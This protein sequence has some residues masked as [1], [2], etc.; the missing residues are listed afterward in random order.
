MF[1]GMG[2]GV[3][4]FSIVF[5]FFIGWFLAYKM[6]LDQIGIKEQMLKMLFYSILISG[7]TF[8]EM[9]MIWGWTVKYLF[10]ENFNI[11]NFGHP[12]ILYDP[13]ISFIGWLVLMIIISPLLQLL[14]AIFGFYIT[15]IVFIKNN[16]TKNPI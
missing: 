13:K 2:M 9:V 14:T 10:L 6:S 5:G 15:Q 16:Q 12:M 7:V 1:I 8:V 11:A 3:P 4:I